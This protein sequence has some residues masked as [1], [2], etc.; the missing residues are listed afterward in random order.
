MNILFYGNC[1]P[2]C[3]KQIL[4]LNKYNQ[5]HIQ[6]YTTNLN[7]SE[8]DNI[9]KICDIIITQL[10]LD[11]Y[12]E[13]EYL[14]TNYII[15]TCKK[16]CKI[17]IF[18]SCHFDF[19]YFDLT[20]KL[21]NNTIMKKPIDYHY[22]KMIECYQNNLP[23]EYYIEKYV[24]NIELKTID[25][26]EVIANNSLNELKNRNNNTIEKYNIT[27][28]IFIITTYDYIKQNYKDKLLFYSMN[29]PSK[30]VLQYIS[31]QILEILQEPNT[32][33]YD[34]DPLNSTKCIIYKC[35]QKVVNFD[36]NQHTPLTNNKTNNYDITELYYN[37]Y[38]DIGFK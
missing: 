5:H 2:G 9:I 4:N 38:K 27:N 26:L 17:I 7:K 25:E 28:N 21:F 33:N 14:S 1:Q 22:N 35:I 23:I 29:H 37:T 31:E 34:I 24:N 32:I 30:Y 3:I 18:D 19:Y 15:S 11:N 20:Y 36:I 6:C 13:K 16:D 12:R 8:F 10:I